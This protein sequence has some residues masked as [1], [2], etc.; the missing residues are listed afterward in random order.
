MNASYTVSF[1][2]F[3]AKSAA[4]LGT[5]LRADMAAYL[6]KISMERVTVILAVERKLPKR[7]AEG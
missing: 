3:A 6:D 4:A 5:M 7:K 1:E 2:G